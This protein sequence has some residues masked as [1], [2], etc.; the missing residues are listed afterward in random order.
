MTG[1]GAVLSTLKLSLSQSTRRMMASSQSLGCPE[2]EPSVSD[3]CDAM[4][5]KEPCGDLWVYL[6][7]IVI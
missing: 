7:L 5:N 4:K 3:A 6:D 1:R 2:I